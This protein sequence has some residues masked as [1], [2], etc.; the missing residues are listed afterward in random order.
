MKKKERM[1]KMCNGTC[2][3]CPYYDDITDTCL[4]DNPDLAIERTVI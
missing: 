1:K 3:N 2:W 4:I